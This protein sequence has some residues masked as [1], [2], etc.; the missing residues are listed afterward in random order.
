MWLWWN[1]PQ[2]VNM[3]TYTP[4]ES[5]IYLEANSL[6]EIVSEMTSTE[7]WKTLAPPAGI[8]PDIGRI[9]WLSH[10]AQWTGIGS[11]ETV[12]LSRA[13]IAVAVLGLDAA[14]GPNNDLNIKPRLALIAET[15][16]SEQRVRA[17][18]EKLVGDFAHRAYG[19]PKV[20]HKNVDDASF[21]IWRATSGERKIVAAVI[22]SVAVI[23]NDEATVQ[24][25]LTVRRG[26]HASLAND[27]QLEEMRERVNGSDALA[28][29]YITPSGISKVLEVAAIAYAGQFS[30]NPKT[31]SAAAILLP[32]LASKLLDS[33][34]WS[35]R[36]REGV[37]EDDYYLALQNG[38]ASRLHDPLI[39]APDQSTNAGEFLPLDTYQ[40]TRYDFQDPEN[41]WRGLNATI[42]SQLDIT[43]AP[44]IGKFLDDSLKPF[45]IENPRDFLRVAGPDINTARVDNAGTSLVL[46]ASIRDEKALRGLLR[47]R[48]GPG[49]HV[50]HIGNAEMSVASDEELGAASVVDHHLI[51]GNADDVRRCL[52]AHASLRTLAQTDAFARTTKFAS[53]SD[54]PASVQTITDDR[55]PA[56]R[57]MLF[58]ARQR[59]ARG[60]SVNEAELQR[61]LDKLFYSLSETRLVDGG[62]EKKTRSSFGLLGTIALQ[63][64]TDGERGK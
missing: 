8:N 49:A 38:I 47:T 35:A 29:G 4:T 56:R 12:V 28:F 63:L 53:T 14:E 50:E 37:V 55:E 10:L 64:T 36:T 24:A 62:F 21:T 25:C 9:G 13:Q 60:G 17:A 6:P 39:P 45:G 58:V 27:P 15:H 18:V 5:L 48:L 40:L 41:A 46:V 54:A 23:G 33:L 19:Q 44:L 16:T 32:Q 11:A 7:S 20:E 31:Q 26:E 51:M 34:A 3:A 30:S 57:F 22:G 42:S 61:S 1:R 52:K 2:K 43:I 59:S